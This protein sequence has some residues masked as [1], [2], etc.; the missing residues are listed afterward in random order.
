MTLKTFTTRSLIAAT[1]LSCLCLFLY[2]VEGNRS[3][4]TH[5]GN[6]PYTKTIAIKGW[7]Q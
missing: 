5:S 3:S 1:W 4:F 7:M 6:Q 2:Q